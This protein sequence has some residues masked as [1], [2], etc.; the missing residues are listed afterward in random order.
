LA[1]GL[2]VYIASTPPIVE[3][4]TEFY[5]LGPSGKAYGY[6]TNLTFG[7]SGTVILGV[8]NREYEDVSYR[9]FVR[10]DDKI[11]E[12]IGSIGLR[13]DEGWE[14]NCTFTPETSGERMKLEFLLYGDDANE[15]YRSLH[16][17]ITVRPRA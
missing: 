15:T 9:I 3:R 13:H 14:R 2:T 4:F 16:L 8:V 11:I 7:D 17:W 1:V 6:P 5:I 10:L 12:T